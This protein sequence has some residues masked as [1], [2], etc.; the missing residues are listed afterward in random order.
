MFNRMAL[1]V[2]RITIFPINSPFSFFIDTDKGTIIRFTSVF[3]KTFCFCS[4]LMF[5]IL[6]K[7]FKLWLRCLKKKIQ[8]WR[9]LKLQFLWRTNGENFKSIFFSQFP[10]FGTPSTIFT[11]DS[12]I[13][14][15]GPSFFSQTKVLGQ[16]TLIW[17]NFFQNVIFFPIRIWGKIRMVSD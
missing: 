3:I 9:Y 15:Y 6:K 10:T 17:K 5:S 13:I 2:S 8:N 11:K 14:F 7:N 16:N 4:R 12:S 1:S